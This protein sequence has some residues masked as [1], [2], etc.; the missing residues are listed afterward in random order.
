[1]DLRGHFANRIL[2]ANI[3]EF[4]DLATA[5][6]RGRVQVLVALKEPIPVSSAQLADAARRSPAGVG[7]PHLDVEPFT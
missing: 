5:L 1:V 6:S 2:T 3:Q 4:L 7:S